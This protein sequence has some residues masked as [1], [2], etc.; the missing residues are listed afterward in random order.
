[1]HSKPS[2]YTNEEIINTL[3]KRPLTDDDI[4]ILFDKT[5]IV[6]LQSLVKEKKVQI[7]TISNLDFYVPTQNLHRKRINPS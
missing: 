7:K 6:R 1:M 3:D 5:S 2:S 4:N